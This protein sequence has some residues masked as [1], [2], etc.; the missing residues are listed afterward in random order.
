MYNGYCGKA[1]N[2]ITFRL[3][4][5]GPMARSTHTFHP[6]V[7]NEG[8]KWEMLRYKDWDDVVQDLLERKVR[9]EDQW[10]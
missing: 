9:V 6:R 1:C 2:R 8:E 10:K 7:V 5:G 3:V 4:S